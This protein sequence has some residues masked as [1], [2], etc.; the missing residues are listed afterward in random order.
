MVLLILGSGSLKSLTEWAFITFHFVERKISFQMPFRGHERFI[1]M[2]GGDTFAML[3]VLGQRAQDKLRELYRRRR[4]AIWYLCGAY[5]PLRS[6]MDFFK[7]NLNFINAK[8]LKYS[9]RLSETERSSFQKVACSTYGCDFVFHV[10]REDVALQMMN[11]YQPMEKE[12]WSAPLFGGPSMLPSKIFEPIAL[13][14]GFTKKTNFLSKKD[15]LEEKP[16]IGNIAVAK[17]VDGKGQSLYL[18]PSFPEHPGII[19]G[20][21][22]PF[23]LWRAEFAKTRMGGSSHS[24][25]FCEIQSKGRN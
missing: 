21:V 6:S 15:W 10:V 16:W 18:R 5:L 20:L 1:L 9:R 3:K 12:S 4:T 13:Y 8:N 7:N 24:K 17:K 22:I 2:S 19:L 25:D 14:K 11:G 23:F